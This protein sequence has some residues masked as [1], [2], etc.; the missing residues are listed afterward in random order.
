MMPTINEMKQGLS[1]I[2][3]T[4]KSFL[5]IVDQIIV[6]YQQLYWKM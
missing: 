6:P 5:Y 1:T 4:L 3:R 2:S